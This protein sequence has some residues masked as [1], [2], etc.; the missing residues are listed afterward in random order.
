MTRPVLTS[1]AAKSDVVITTA[2]IPALMFFLMMIALGLGAGRFSK[3][4]AAR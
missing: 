2:Q 3:S 1:K 4:P